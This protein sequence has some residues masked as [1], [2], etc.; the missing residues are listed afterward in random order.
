M[1]DVEKNHIIH[2]LVWQ[3][4][5][6]GN[7]IPLAGSE[8]IQSLVVGFRTR[9]RHNVGGRVEEVHDAGHHACRKNSKCPVAAAEIGHALTVGG[10]P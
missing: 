8:V 6:L 10:Q 4:A 1:K 7:E 3:S 9:G 2:V 5:A